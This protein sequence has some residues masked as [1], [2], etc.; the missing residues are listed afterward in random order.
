M[1]D[2]DVAINSSV[3][4]ATSIT[5]RLVTRSRFRNSAR[6]DPGNI[7]CDSGNIQFDS[8]NIQFD[9]RNIQFD[10]GALYARPLIQLPQIHRYQQ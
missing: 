7:Q 2:V 1:R 8:R 9:S 6:Y 3:I 4:T 10:L 5:G